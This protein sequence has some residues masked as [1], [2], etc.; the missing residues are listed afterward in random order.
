MTLSDL[1]TPAV[2]LSRSRLER[3]CAAMAARLGAHGVR[4]RPHMKT[5][6][7]AEVAAI[8]TRGQFGG[9]TVSTLAEA[10][11]F[12]AAGV[13]DIVYA[14]GIVPSKLDQAAEI[15]RAG[16]R[17]TIMT[18][19]SSVAAALAARAPALGGSF[20]V[21]I[22]VDTGGARA[23]VAPESGELLEIGRR[24]HE[25]EGLS[26]EGVLTHA[27]HSY[28]CRGLDEIRAV[29]EAERSGVARAAARL[30]GAGLPC[31]VVSA[32]STPTATHAANLDGV[33][34]MRPGVYMFGDLDQ[35]F[36]E[37][38]GRDDIA[39]SVLASVIG[40]NRRAGRILVDAGG[41]ALSKDR[42]ANEFDPQA[43]YG[44]ACDLGCRPFAPALYVADVHQEH[45]LIAGRDG[46]APPYEL[47]PVG[48]R[49]RILPNHAC[50]TA[51]AY[52]EY[53]V[54]GEDQAV[55]AV[56]PRV[57]GW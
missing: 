21:L 55:E 49:V 53:Q 13:T 34:E 51:A 27:G 48:A 57:N 26:L 52:G 9:I 23:G 4:L 44:W 45:G 32:G 39:V 5:A 41:L 54:V 1:K 29:A 40:H 56:W 3:N 6:K 33:T 16:A 8:A 38:C 20:P 11:Y 36:L 25:A 50:M 24:L 22:E 30:R 46:A 18:D 2:L 12:A 35:M 42:S 43:G 15:R 47:L 7:S 10:A 28:H 31:P 17:L 19:D 14:V 37:S